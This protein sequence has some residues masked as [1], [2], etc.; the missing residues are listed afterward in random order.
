MMLYN[1]AVSQDIM[2]C[3]TRTE[4][5]YVFKKIMYCHPPG[6]PESANLKKK[7]EV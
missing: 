5:Q 3:V 6:P 4:I 1:I 2:Y 7:M